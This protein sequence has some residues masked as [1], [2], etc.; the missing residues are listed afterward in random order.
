MP[1]SPPVITPRSSSVPLE[2]L[3]RLD[4]LTYDKESDLKLMYFDQELGS[5]EEACQS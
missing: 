4:R 3:D 1:D 5:H 2:T